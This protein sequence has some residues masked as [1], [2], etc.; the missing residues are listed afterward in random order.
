[1]RRCLPEAKIAVTLVEMENESQSVEDTG[2]IEEN[3]ARVAET[4]EKE[5]Q[6]CAAEEVPLTLLLFSLESHLGGEPK[7]EE[8]DILEKGLLVHCGRAR[9]FICR[10]GF[11]EFVA[12]LPHTSPSGG[13]HIG[14]Q[15]I[16][17]ITLGCP[18]PENPRLSIGVAALV[19]HLDADREYLRRHAERALK[20]AKEQR[21]S[22]VLGAVARAANATEKS[23]IPW[24]RQLFGL[25]PS[26][27]AARRQSDSDYSKSK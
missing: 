14:H 22:S 1:M 24:W 12:I 13:L 17:T 10:R 16:E 11:A 8:I 4:L 15:L 7:K 3:F 26:V 21:G 19:P 6:R 5:W 20:Q 25:G 9:D 18:S 23:G 27:K 2:T